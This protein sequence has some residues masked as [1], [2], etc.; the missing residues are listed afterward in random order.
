[1]SEIDTKIAEMMKKLDI[2]ITPEVLDV[3]E[4]SPELPSG[5]TSH[6]SG[7]RMGSR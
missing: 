5:G 2:S 4:V 1:M 3:V 6:C 7:S